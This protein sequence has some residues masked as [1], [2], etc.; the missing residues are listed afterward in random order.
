MI[1]AYNEAPRIA[2]VVGGCL[3]V[4]GLET[5][6]VVDDGSTDG[7]A[8]RAR[9]AGAA[10]LRLE[11]NRGKG[12]ALAAGFDRALA[13]GH[14]WVVTL[15]GDAQH[16]PAE[17]PRFLEVARGRGADVVLGDRLVHPEGMPP[18]RWL[19]NRVMSLVLSCLAGVQMADTQCGF[20]LFSD[21]VLR[22]VRPR[23]LRFSYESELLVG[24]GRRGYRFARV[25]VRSIYA[26]GPSR[27]RPLPD[28]ARFLAL[29]LRLVG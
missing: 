6:L 4:G 9:E 2:R 1:P 17:V 5:V 15:D 26:G 16:D 8:E 10:V 27:I 21:R 22:A 11:P 28:T 25:P 14:R 12:A 20:R 29:V 19:T 18:I 13:A 7:T 24:A 23:S 3:R